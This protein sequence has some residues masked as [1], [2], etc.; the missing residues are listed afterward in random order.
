MA[1][2]QRHASG[3]ERRQSH[4]RHFLDYH[5]NGDLCVISDDD[6]EG[7]T[8]RRLRMSDLRGVV[9]K[10]GGNDGGFLTKGTV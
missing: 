4:H 8:E 7:E 9:F 3:H 10:H 5:G 1:G 6:V 2:S